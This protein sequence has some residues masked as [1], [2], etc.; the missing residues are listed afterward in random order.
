MVICFINLN[1]RYFT[2]E[3]NKNILKAYLLHELGHCFSPKK[4]GSSA[5]LCAQVWAIEK[6]K[7]MNMPVITKILENLVEEWVT[8]GWKHKKLR[9]YIRA[10]RAYNKIKNSKSEIKNLL[11]SCGKL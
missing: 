3:L 4:M 2:L 9:I 7:K 5:E 6:S 8:M 11:K 1:K 10:G